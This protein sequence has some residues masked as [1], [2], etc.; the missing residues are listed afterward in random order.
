MSLLDKLG[1]K[2]EQRKEAQIKAVE[3]EKKQSLAQINAQILETE[4][5]KKR[6][7]DLSDS[8]RASFDNAKNKLT[9]FK[10]KK[11]ILKGAYEDSKD[12][13]EEDDGITSFEGMLE[14]N[15]GEPE[16]KAYR[17]A[18][19]RG[20]AKEKGAKRISEDE[21]GTT[22]DLYKAVG[23]IQE[24]SKSLRAEMG[25]A[26]KDKKELNFSAV[27]KD[28]EISNREANFIQIDE[29]LKT[30]DIKLVELNKQKEEALADTPEGKRAAVSKIDNIAYKL[31][32]VDFGN[33]ES[34]GFETR[35]IELSEKI[36]P[37][38]IKEV[39]TEE[40]EKR[41]TKIAWD[42][43]RPQRSGGYEEKSEAQQAIEAYPAMKELASHK[44]NYQDLN[45]FEE[46]YNK[47]LIHLEKIFKTSKT[48]HN[49]I[50]SYG[51]RGSSKERERY[52][53]RG[54]SQERIYADLYLK[55]LEELIHLT[56]HE[57][58]LDTVNYRKDTPESHTYSPEF[59]H[60][61]F[62]KYKKLLG[63]IIE[64]TNTETK[65][66]GEFHKRDRDD[67]IYKAQNDKEIR[68]EM[69]LNEKDPEKYLK[70]PSEFINKNGGFQNAY[71]VANKEGYAWEQDKKE[72]AAISK[73]VV[74]ERFAQVWES[75]FN[76]KNKAFFEG[77]DY[78]EKLTKQIEYSLIYLKNLQR[79]G[80]LKLPAFAGRKIKLNRNSS[81]YNERS[82][83][84]DL[85]ADKY[86]KVSEEVH[87]IEKEIKEYTE[88]KVG[89]LEKSMGE[90]KRGFIVLNRDKKLE[91]LNSKWQ[92]FKDFGRGRHYVEENRF[93]ERGASEKEI[94]EM[95]NLDLRYH[96]NEDLKNK[97]EKENTNFS[98]FFKKE[99][100]HIDF[101]AG[102]DI[103][104]GQEMTLEELPSRLEAR[105]AELKAEKEN[106]SEAELAIIAERERSIKEV[107]ELKDKFPTIVRNSGNVIDKY[108][109]R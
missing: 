103:L 22:G 31:D 28:S 68:E 46:V 37:E 49:E 30:L 21:V 14:A 90:L 97:L 63:Y 84:D 29:F 11:G 99:R 23:T 9:D 33:L 44:Y 13:L 61:Q 73:A 25:I 59:V 76:Q 75:H 98:E 3:E 71:Q 41:L 87:K 18:G 7:K 105:L 42:K 6:I 72:I 88:Q 39:Y 36:G 77:L 16:V 32:R 101:K 24:L 69:G 5:K 65:F 43:K 107:K 86:Y 2:K 50:S 80:V 8:L 109:K 108:S 102:K 64:K 55:H 67:F 53:E 91:A 56:H 58:L 19:G 35:V 4:V 62:E 106:L 47:V 83:V 45:E 12:I 78:N 70:Y 38:P 79:D 95:K 54:W 17:R 85:S 74:E 66:L 1:Q 15:E 27:K 48:T 34:F 10:N 81:N 100:F 40:M 96:D 82:I 57:T 60:A 89:E 20:P 51:L 104:D 92:V 26:E 52:E 93:K 94:E